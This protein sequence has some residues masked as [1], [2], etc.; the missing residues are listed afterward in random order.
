MQKYPNK[1]KG[2][3]RDGV[4]TNLVNKMKPYL[5]DLLLNLPLHDFRE[6]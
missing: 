5:N 3:R 6:R 2:I 1:M 4:A